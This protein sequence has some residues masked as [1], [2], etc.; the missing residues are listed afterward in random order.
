MKRLLTVTVL[1]LGT[2]VFAA[3]G[4]ADPGPGGK[5]QRAHNGKLGPFAL[6]TEDNGSCG[7]PWAVLQDRRIF[8]VKDNGDGTFRLTRRDRG[9]FVTTGP[10]SPGACEKTFP[11]GTVV[12]AGAKGKFHGFLVGTISGGTFNPKAACGTE[13][14]SST[15]AFITT[16]FGANAQF[17]CFSDS[18]DCRFA[19]EYSAPAQHLRLHHWQ[20]RGTGAGT[21][22]KERFKGDISNDRVKKSS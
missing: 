3:L 15:E 5:S 14:Q 19:Y 12:S 16:F 18:K 13:C 20:D 22:L 2:L 1:A 8:K 7:T 10:K 11:H 17:S 21:M 9:T 6:T 4:A